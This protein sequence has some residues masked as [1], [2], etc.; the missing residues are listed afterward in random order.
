MSQSSQALDATDAT[1]VGEKSSGKSINIQ[2]FRALLSLASAALLIR[3]MGMLYQVVVTARFGAGTTMDAYFVAFSLPYLLAQLIV[4]A[5]EYSVMPVYARICTQQ[6]KE[7]RSTLFST[8]LNL[9]LIVGALLTIV[10]F[11]FR[12]QMIFLSA[13]TLDLIRAGLAI[14]LAPFILPILLLSIVIGF[15]ESILNAEGQFGWPAYAGLLVPLTTTVFIL[16]AGQSHGIVML[17]IGMATGLCL[18]LC[19]FIIRIKRAR[20]VYR[21]TLNLHIVEIGLIAAAVG[22][23]FLG[24]L[25]TEVSPLIDQAFASFLLPGSI[26]ALNYALKFISVFTGVLFGSVARALLPHLSRQAATKDLD[27][28]KEILHLYLWMLAIGTTLLAT[29]LIVL[30]HPLVQILFQRGAFTAADTSRTASTLVGF[31]VGLTPMAFGFVLSRSLN[32]LYKNHLLLYVAIFSMFANALFDYI[33]ARLWQGVGI[34]LA[35]SAVYFCTMFI[36]LFMLRSTVGTLHLFMPPREVQVITLR[37]IRWMRPEGRRMLDNFYNMHRYIIHTIIIISVFAAGIAGAIQDYLY[38]LRIALG[39]VAIVALLRYRYA[40]LLAWALYTV[41]VRSNPVLA[42]NNVLTG[43]IAPTMLLMT[44]M[45]LNQTFKRL[46]ALVPLS[47]YL[48]WVFAS[49][50]ISPMGIRSFLTIWTIYLAYAALGVL[51]INVLT[52]QRRI[53]ALIDIMLLSTTI[54][55]L[56][57]I[58]GYITKQNGIVDNTV[59]FRIF[60]IFDSSPSLALFLSLTIPLALYRV[61]TTRGFKCVGYSI[62]LLIFLTALVLTFTRTTFISVPVSIIIV[63][64]LLPSLK[65]K[66]G[67]LSALFGLASLTALATKVG[68]IPFLDR[69][70]SQDISTLNGRT[71]IWHILLDRF[72]LTH[73]LVGNGLQASDA[74]LARLYGGYGYSLPATA[75][76]SLFVGALYDHGVIG[77]T[78]L[79]LVFSVQFVSLIRGMRRV[80][81]NHRLLFATAIAVLVGVVLQSLDS[82]DLWIEDFAIYF[83]IIMALPFAHGWPLPKQPSEE[84]VLQVHY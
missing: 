47:L 64:L 1:A 49:I 42:G 76:H 29:C 35:T 60:S 61:L 33:F 56:Y 62:L 8:L 15:L 12:R 7:L 16:A 46:P 59:G 19:L 27:R 41:V 55:A 2:I 6:D 24:G 67:V 78:L 77:V 44:V 18:Q 57:G 50:G 53:L 20:L 66:V 82:S 48:L 22:P 30:A 63:I 21:F 81:G 32:A 45:P 34:A 17:C 75:P 38:T 71:I 79:V 4:G 54:I 72:N 51:V 83:W 58:Y 31:T 25:V 37:V 39:S 52:T 11:I 65:M 74:V 9:S 5:I 26:S 14:D 3:V 70:Y 10:L 13:P 73:L 36:L 43:L 68:N 84:E 69:F 40:L 80:S 28:F 23:A